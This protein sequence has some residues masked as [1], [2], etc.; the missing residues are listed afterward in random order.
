MYSYYSIIV[1]LCITCT[2]YSLSDNDGTCDSTLSFIED[3]LTNISDELKGSSNGVSES[4]SSVTS[5]FQLSFLK[6]L[7]GSYKE[8]SS[9]SSNE[10]GLAILKRMELIL[11][12]STADITSKLE[13]TNAR[14]S[15]IEQQQQSQ[16]SSLSSDLNKLSRLLAKHVNVTLDDEEEAPSSP[17]LSSCDAI[18]SKWPNSPSGYYNLADVNGHTR[19]VYCHMETLCGKGGGWRRIA[20]LN[21]TDPNEKCPTQFRTYSQDGVRAC[22]RPVT[23][24][25]SCVGITFSSRDIKY[26]QVCGKVIGYQDGTTNG[27][28][29]RHASKDI[30]SAYIDGISLTHGNPRK[31]IWTLVSGYTGIG[32]S[33]CPCGS[34][35]PF[36]VPTFV[37]SHYL[38]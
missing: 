25:G 21:M 2:S 31:H 20:S 27:A 26:S 28:A 7:I 33:D 5:L 16:V 17:L 35:T 14:L 3:S 37:S 38:L 15:A 30:N 19:H 12:T 29:A 6:E 13:D 22:G 8:K 11:N 10:E 23:N 4:L 1:L 9:N 34:D 24:S 32:A 36:P 18:L